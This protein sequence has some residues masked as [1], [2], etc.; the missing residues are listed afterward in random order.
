M[1]EFYLSHAVA[2]Q[3][4]TPVAFVRNVSNAIQRRGHVSNVRTLED[5]RYDAIGRAALMLH[6]LLRAEVHYVAVTVYQDLRLHQCMFDM[7][8]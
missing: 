5:N 8:Q 4:E 1:R 3:E 6:V 2:A 7:V